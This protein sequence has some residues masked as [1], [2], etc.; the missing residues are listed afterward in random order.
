[1]SCL[2]PGQ[3]WA[4]SSHNQACAGTSAS[5]EL[6]G[7]TAHL[8]HSRCPC[9]ACVEK[10]WNWERNKALPPSFETTQSRHESPTGSTC[11][12]IHITQH[13]SRKACTSGRLPAK[14]TAT[15]H[16]GVSVIFLSLS[17]P[18]FLKQLP[19]GST[20]GF[21]YRYFT[22]FVLCWILQPAAHISID[23]AGCAV[24]RAHTTTSG[25]ASQLPALQ[26]MKG[27]IQIML[28]GEKK[29]NKMIF[30]KKKKYR[31]PFS[32]SI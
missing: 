16:F 18:H 31:K 17:T 5:A 26:T 25:H 15:G 9:W 12:A 27:A 7:W 21:E 6:W 32:V 22:Y 23:K 19:E 13:P 8:C 29:A 1:M 20:V 4:S 24:L 10:I 2:L 11:N 3:H 30:E 14:T 28:F